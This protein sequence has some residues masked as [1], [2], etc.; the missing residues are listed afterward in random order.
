[1]EISGEDAFAELVTMAIQV[2]PS[3]AERGTQA[4]AGARG[5]AASVVGEAPH[6]LSIPV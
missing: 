2:D 1:M 6:L 5:G 3:L 4:L